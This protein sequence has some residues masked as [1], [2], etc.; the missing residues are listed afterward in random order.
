M[1]FDELDKARQRTIM[2]IIVF[3]F[4]G[5]AFLVVPERYLPFMGSACGFVLVVWAVVSIIEFAMGPKVLIRYFGLFVALAM[6]VLGISLFVFDS[7][8]LR[9]LTGLVAVIPILGGII[10]SYHALVFARRSG[11]KGWWIPLVL[12]VLLIIFGTMTLVNPWSYNTRAVLE[13]IGGTLAYTAVVYALLLVWMWPK[14]G[15]DTR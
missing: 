14:R 7:L 10:G 13:L 3:V 12:T 9:L 5:I 1:L 2:T 6:G 8:F 11:R 4:V 15:E